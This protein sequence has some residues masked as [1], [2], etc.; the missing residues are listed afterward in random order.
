[1]EGLWGLLIMA[2]VFGG[3]LYLFKMI[4]IDETVKKVVTVVALIVFI[5]MVIKWLMGN[6]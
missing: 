6:V 4:P 3:V 2:V 1:M 5:V